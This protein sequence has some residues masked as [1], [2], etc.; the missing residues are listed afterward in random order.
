MRIKMDD[1]VASP[2]L[3]HFTTT[4]SLIFCGYLVGLAVMAQIIV[5]KT[6]STWMQMQRVL[7]YLVRSIHILLPAMEFREE[8]GRYVIDYKV[9]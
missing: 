8:F 7:H 5:T 3:I 9:T 6:A 2:F 4:A 1:S